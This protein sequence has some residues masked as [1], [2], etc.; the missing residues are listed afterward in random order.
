MDILAPLPDTH[1]GRHTAWLWSRM[2]AIAGGSPPPGPGELAA[3]FA[4]SVF[5]QLPAEQLIAALAQV[6]PALPLVTR[7]VEEASSDQRYTALLALPGSWLRYTCL[8]QDDEPHLLVA[9]AYLPAL[10]PN[11]YSDRRVQHAGR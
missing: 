10:D 5:E 3:H 4:P 1:A 2:L 6:A 9:A 7:L 11:G 8:A